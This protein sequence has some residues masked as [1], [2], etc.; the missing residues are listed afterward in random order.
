[1]TT[2]T[3]ARWNV[4]VSSDTDQSVRMFL[5]SCGKAG[6]KGE[7]SKFI[8]TATRSHLFDLA[9]EQAKISNA[10]VAEADLSAMIAESVDWARA[11]A[12]GR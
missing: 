5:A 2:E 1:M 11:N 10:H 8:E 4:A 3:I 6:R 9:V 12:S 7:L